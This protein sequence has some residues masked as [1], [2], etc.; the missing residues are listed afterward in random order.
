MKPTHPISLEFA[1]KSYEFLKDKVIRTPLFHST[2][3]SLKL[4]SQVHLKHEN[5]QKT[6]SFKIRGAMNKI[7]SLSQSECDRGLIASSAGNHAQGVAHAA[8]QRNISVK[9]VMPHSSP[10]VKRKAT[11]GYGAE[12]VLHG[13]F[14]DESYEYA[15]KL[16]EEE[17]RIFIHPFDDPYI[18]G[19]QSGPRF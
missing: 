3:L 17:S 18:V 1:Q 4:G 10:F 15:R 2:S 7:F 14:Y 12:V 6:G 19:G 5:Q 11:Q 8:A 13:E 9:V 16:Q